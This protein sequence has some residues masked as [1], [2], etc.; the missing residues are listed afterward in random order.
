MIRFLGLCKNRL[1]PP[2]SYYVNVE[3]SSDQ[4]VLS[5]SC[6]DCCM[7]RRWRDV[8]MCRQTVMTQLGRDHQ[9]IHAFRWVAHICLC[10]PVSSFHSRSLL[11]LTSI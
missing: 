10:Q 8:W 7:L 4:Y 5:S 6:R 2:K 11:F 9:L 1:A 3:Y